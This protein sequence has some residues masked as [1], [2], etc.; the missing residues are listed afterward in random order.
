MHIGFTGTRNTP[1][2]EQLIILDS[3]LHS[4][5]TFHGFTTFHH[6]DC[7]GSDHAAALL[8][9]DRGYHVISH[10]PL[11]SRYR[12]FVRSH[13]ENTPLDY[14]ERDRHIVQSSN[15]MISLTRKEVSLQEILNCENGT[16]RGGTYYTTRYALK[17]NKWVYLV[18][19]KGSIEYGVHLENNTVELKICQ[20]TSLKSRQLKP[21]LKLSQNV[22]SVK[23][24]LQDNK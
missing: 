8:A 15:L 14:L 23:K 12:A 20:K 21:V 4:R 7:V 24:K 1:T 22:S 2:D 11:D 9:Q 10:P 18:T 16:S 6:G 3:Y 19:P 17:H 5:K 13:K